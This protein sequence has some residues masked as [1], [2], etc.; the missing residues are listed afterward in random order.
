MHFYT[1]ANLAP[2]ASLIV[3]DFTLAVHGSSCIHIQYLYALGMPLNKKSK[4]RG[5]IEDEKVGIT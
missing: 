3:P 1:V 5:K 4:L 2:E